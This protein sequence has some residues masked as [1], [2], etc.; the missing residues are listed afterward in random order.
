MNNKKVAVSIYVFNFLEIG[1]KIDELIE[2]GMEWIHVDIMDGNFVNNYAL[3]Q[4]FCKDIK[5][6]YPKIKVDAHMMCSNSEKYIESFAEAG[7]DYFIFH[8]ETLTDKNPIT[9]NNIINKI[10]SYNMK[11]IIALNP[12]TSFE[13]IKTYCD[14]LYAVMCMNILPG[15]NGQKIIESSYSKINIINKYRKENNKVFKI[16]TDGGLREDTYKK[17]LDAGADIVVVGAFVNVENNKLKGQ[18]EKIKNY[19]IK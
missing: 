10:K 11:P 12:E 9:V 3:C 18:F 6:K 8:Y 17:I 4:K 19:E 16:M 15:F 1:K 2:A 14:D 5:D 13:H 7:C